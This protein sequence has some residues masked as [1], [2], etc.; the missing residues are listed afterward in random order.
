MK[1]I[2]GR[3]LIYSG[4]VDAC[5]QGNEDFRLRFAKQSL[6]A[7]LV[8]YAPEEKTGALKEKET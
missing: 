1:D 5:I 6:F 2:P 8:Y 4:H 3:S 7:S